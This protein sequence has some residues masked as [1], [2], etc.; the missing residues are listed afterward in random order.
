MQFRT[1]RMSFQGKELRLAV[2]Y[3]PSLFLRVKLVPDILPHNASELEL[4][5][6]REN[7][8]DHGAGLLGGGGLGWAVPC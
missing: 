7:F 1:S 3:F 2:A 4:L 6:G 8:V 5:A